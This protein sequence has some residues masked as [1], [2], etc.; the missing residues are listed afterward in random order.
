M[1]TEGS[2]LCSQQLAIRPYP[3]PVES[4]PHPHTLFLSV[5]FKNLSLIYAHFSKILNFWNG[6][7]IV[8]FKY[9]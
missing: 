3:Q 6:I 5:S 8:L 2:L 9:C 1:K 4:S 7:K